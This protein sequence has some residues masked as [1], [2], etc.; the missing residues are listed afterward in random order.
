M[1]TGRHLIAAVL[2]T[3]VVFCGC[4]HASPT[5]TT[6]VRTTRSAT[7]SGSGEPGTSTSRPSRAGRVTGQVLV[8][9]PG[10]GRSRRVG[11]QAV[12]MLRGRTHR[13]LRTN[14]SGVFSVVL[15]TGRYSVSGHVPGP[16]QT[17][18][19]TPRHMT[20]VAGH[21]SL[22]RFVCISTAGRSDAQR[23]NRICR[24][25]DDRVRVSVSAV[26][27]RRAAWRQVNR[28]LR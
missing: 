3:S 15:P 5:A 19:P 20:L 14:A 17:L 23:P 21:T 25:L 9:Q 28:L 11:Q 22:A 26:A 6:S 16:I 7:D 18:C 4:T 12:V 8:V 13:R 10:F 1:A 24:R 27:G 2:L